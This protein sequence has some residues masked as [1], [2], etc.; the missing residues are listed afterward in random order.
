[1]RGNNWLWTIDYCFRIWLTGDTEY[2]I[3]TD[4]NNNCK[5]RHIYCEHS[6]VGIFHGID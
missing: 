2:L 6:L 3:E 5:F 1:M 4:Y